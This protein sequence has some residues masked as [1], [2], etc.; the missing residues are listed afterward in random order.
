MDQ[1]K[2]SQ[3]PGS[4]KKPPVK[5]SRPPK[6][7]GSQSVSPTMILLIVVAL[8]LMIVGGVLA[9]RSY[10]QKAQPQA[11]GPGQTSQT[12]TVSEAT[13][14]EITQ[15]IGNKNPDGMAKFY[16]DKVKVVIV[17]QKFNKTLLAGQV[18]QYVNNP[19]NSAQTPWDWNVSP[20][21]LSAWQ[22]GPYGEYF[23][24]NVLVGISADGTVISIGFND[25][26]EIVTIFIAPASDLTDPATGS[27]PAQDGGTSSPD[28]GTTPPTNLPYNGVD[29]ND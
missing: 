14:Q 17:R 23:T 1:Y 7:R 4:G 15:A 16:A 10:K 29:Y 3:N 2:V 25:Q 6:R 21:D 13:S 12:G 11:G 19:L 26:G 9:W 28:D 8:L 18:G 22:T 20:S 5:K 27:T 24:G